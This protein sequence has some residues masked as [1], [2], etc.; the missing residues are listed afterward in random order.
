MT[1]VHKTVDARNLTCP[2]PVLKARK[3]LKEVEIDKVL[4]IL[5]RDTESK[6][7][8]TSWIREAG[9]ELM[10]LEERGPRDFRFLIKRLN[11]F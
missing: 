2:L 8:I 9:Q 1:K 3:D 10:V 11:E 6:E 7:C 4:E 5:R